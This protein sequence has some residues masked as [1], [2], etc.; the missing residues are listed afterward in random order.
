VQ[1]SASG[2]KLASNRLPC[3]PFMEDMDDE[4]ILLKCPNK[5]D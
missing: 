4:L 1:R 3:R 2:L 5:P